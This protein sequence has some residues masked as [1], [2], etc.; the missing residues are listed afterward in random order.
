MAETASEGALLGADD[1]VDTGG[2]AALAAM[3]AEA[4]AG[5]DGARGAAAQKRSWFT[6]LVASY[7]RRSQAKAAARP[8]GAAAARGQSETDAAHAAIRAACVK[9]AITGFSAGAVSTA[10]TMLTAETEGL[11]G[12]VTMPVL[13][14]TIGGELMYRSVVH[15]DLVCELARIFDVTFDVGDERDLW[16]LYALAFGTHGHDEESSDPGKELVHDITHIEG[17]QVG[18]K[19]GSK[20]LGE[21]VVRNIVPFVGMASSAITN[22]VMTRRLGDTVRRAM[23]YQ[24][25]MDDALRE[26][27]EL[28]RDQLDLLI[29]GM[30][31]IF[32]ADGRLTPEET[33][34][35][36]KL[37][38]RLD[39]L[40]RHAVVARFV[41]D[42]LDWTERIAK[43]VS[44]PLRDP[45]LHALEV[46]AAVDKEVGLPERKILRRAAHA[47]GRHF[48]LDHVLGMVSSFEERGVL[49]PR[50]D[51]HRRRRAAT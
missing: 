3:R 2:D 4:I 40:Q 43:E 7:L 29:E 24:R 27:S 39:P 13:A 31:F 21:S 8:R 6:R 15:V 19:V 48:D 10:A 20:V 12:V 16:R 9:S 37:L 35:L 30:W 23:R 32:T 44:E 38:Q 18:E 5:A 26:T 51:H 11:A 49:D 42:E 33:V 41:E 45:F 50:P 25:A 17:E 1:P 14:L 28:C 22:Y 46:A 47:L 36:A 34:C